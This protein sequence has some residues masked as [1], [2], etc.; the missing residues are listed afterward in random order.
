MGF[1]GVFCRNGS[2]GK[3]MEPRLV[4]AGRR[5]VKL[6]EDADVSRFEAMAMCGL[7][8]AE[9]ELLGF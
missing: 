7:R 6:P 5:A 3:D 1:W 2:G 4:A 8:E 9:K